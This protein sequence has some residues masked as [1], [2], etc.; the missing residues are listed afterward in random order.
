VLYSA[1]WWAE[2]SAQGNFWGE[3]QTFG[4]KGTQMPC[5]FKS[6]F[7]HCQTSWKELGPGFGW[8]W[9]DGVVFET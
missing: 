2:K 4:K 9:T 3:T 7:K 8:F 5:S 1:A 6:H